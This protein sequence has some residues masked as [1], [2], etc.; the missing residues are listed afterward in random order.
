[1]MQCKVPNCGGQILETHGE[2]RC[3]LC[4]R[5]HWAL[6]MVHPVPVEL[7]RRRLNYPHSPYLK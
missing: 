6:G 5:E 2:L 4:N 1:M 3:L 7:A